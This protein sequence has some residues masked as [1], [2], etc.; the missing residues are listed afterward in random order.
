MYKKNERMGNGS[1]N[2]SREVALEQWPV[3]ERGR[4][5]SEIRVGEGAGGMRNMSLYPMT[6]P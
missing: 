2:D 6:P 1:K 4:T 5:W 3:H